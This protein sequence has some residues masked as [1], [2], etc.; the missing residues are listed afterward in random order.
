M[1]KANCYIIA[2]PNGAGKSEN[3][4]VYIPHQISVFNGDLIL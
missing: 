1:Q 4:N 3:A 2:G